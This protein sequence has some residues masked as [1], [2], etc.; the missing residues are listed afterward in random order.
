MIDWLRSNVRFD[1]QNLNEKSGDKFCE[2]SGSW[3]VHGRAWLHLF[4]SRAERRGITINPSWHL[5]SRFC[6]ANVRYDHHDDDLTFSIALPP[7]ALWLSFDGVLPRKFKQYGWGRVTGISFH[8]WTV[9]IEVWA[10]DSCWNSRDRWWQRRE[11]HLN[12]LDALLGRSDYKECQMDEVKTEIGMPEGSYPVRIRKLNCT[13]KRPRWPWPQRLVRMDIKPTENAIPVPGK[14]ENSWDCG[15]DA[16]Y[17]SIMPAATYDEAIG[18]FVQGIMRDRTRRA[19]IN[20]RP[21]ERHP[22]KKGG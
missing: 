11:W 1:W 3:I 10:D 21:K 8:D 15:E 9:R 14:G 22:I 12:I 13:W 20:W 5:W 6:H 17:G 16:S 2:P 18:K 7:I 19:G 4:D